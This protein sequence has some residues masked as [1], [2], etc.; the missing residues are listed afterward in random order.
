MDVFVM[1]IFGYILVC[2]VYVFGDVVFVGDMLF[3]FDGGLV[4]VDFFGGDVGI[5]FDLI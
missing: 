5:L 1:Y 3:M 4:C 2:M